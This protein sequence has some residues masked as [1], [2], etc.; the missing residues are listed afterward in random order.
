MEVRSKF[1]KIFQ[2]PQKK[3]KKK[4][5]KKPSIGEPLVGPPTGRVVLV[6]TDI[7]S[8]TM[9]WEK[10]AQAMHDAIGFLSLFL[11]FFIS[12]FLYFFISLFRYFVI[13]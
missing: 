4:K 12:L 5:K 9:L 3:K 10:D 11:Y 1:C 6:F 2:V 13:S 7:K 8:S